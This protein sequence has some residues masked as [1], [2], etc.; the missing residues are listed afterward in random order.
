MLNTTNVNIYTVV[1]I[2]DGFYWKS[3]STKFIS[4]EDYDE[5]FHN[6]IAL[7]KSADKIPMTCES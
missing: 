5:F 1:N 2:T 4:H 7:I 3:N 6:D